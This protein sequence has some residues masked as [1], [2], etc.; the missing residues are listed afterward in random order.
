MYDRNLTRNLTL[1]PMIQTVFEIFMIVSKII[2]LQSSL[3]SERIFQSTIMLLDPNSTLWT[4][5]L[6]FTEFRY[7]NPI[8]ISK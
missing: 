3:H 6:F 1:I 5:F 4:H 7:E 2:Q 8:S